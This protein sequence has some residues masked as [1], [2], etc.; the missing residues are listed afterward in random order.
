MEISIRSQLVC[1]L[2]A[3]AF[4]IFSAILFGIFH[5]ICCFL[6]VR[7]GENERRIIRFLQ[8]SVQI[9]S[10]LLFCIA[11]S[12]GFQILIYAFDYGRF[13]LV[14]I[15]SASL[16]FILYNK[17]L[18]QLTDKLFGKLAQ[19][20]VVVI[21]FVLRYV[22][23]PLRL[24]ISI[25]IKVWNIVVEKVILKPY[26]AYVRKKNIKN[27]RKLIENDLANYIEF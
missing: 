6:C 13:R 20:I 7:H 5:F 17:T 3:F 16:G 4:G 22:L 18:G 23:L 24:L 21:A 9:I 26:R 25:I 2:A 19:Y 27:V 10:D 11:I 1:T 8:Y 12:V 14:Y 15:L